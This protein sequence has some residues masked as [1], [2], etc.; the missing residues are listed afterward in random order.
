MGKEAEPIV[1][2]ALPCTSPAQKQAEQA[3]THDAERETMSRGRIVVDWAP[4]TTPVLLYA[5]IESAAAAAVADRDERVIGKVKMFSTLTVAA[6]C[7]EMHREKGSMRTLC[8]IVVSTKVRGSK[9]GTARVNA[10][11]RATVSDSRGGVW[12]L[13]QSM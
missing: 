10:P 4:R 1:N 2:V 9:S 7:P 13:P 5:M 8:T 12:E 3:D 11:T 6:P